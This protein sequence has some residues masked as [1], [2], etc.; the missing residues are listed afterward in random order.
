MRTG[1]N[2]QLKGGFGKISDFNMYHNVKNLDMLE[3]YCENPRL[4]GE[5]V[6]M[7]RFTQEEKDRYLTERQGI[8]SFV[9]NTRRKTVIMMELHGLNIA[10][11]EKDI[12]THEQ[13][14]NEVRKSLTPKVIAI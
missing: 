14:K 11:L 12:K 5:D 7:I 10:K 13:V 9:N 2:K 6:D 8:V 4:F 3:R 1:K